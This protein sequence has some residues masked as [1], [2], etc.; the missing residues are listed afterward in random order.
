MQVRGTV[1]AVCEGRTVE[2]GRERTTECEED[3]SNVTVPDANWRLDSYLTAVAVQ[4]CV[5]F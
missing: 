2:D 5:T 4:A 1:T 3:I